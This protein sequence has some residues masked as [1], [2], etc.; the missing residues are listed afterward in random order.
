MKGYMTEMA[1][2]W[3]CCRGTYISRE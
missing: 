1:E 2:S 3:R